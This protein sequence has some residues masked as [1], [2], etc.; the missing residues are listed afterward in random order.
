MIKKI[1]AL[2]LV[3]LVGMLFVAGC[4][5]DDGDDKSPTGDGS[6]AGSLTTR[7]DAANETV[8]EENIDQVTARVNG[9]TWDVFGRALSTAQAGKALIDYTSKLSGEVEGEAGGK[10]TVSGNMTTKMSGTSPSSVNYDF[11]CTFYDFSDD[12]E[13]W[14]GGKLTYK[15]DYN[16]TSM[17][18]NINITG[19]IRFNGAYEG[20]Q[21]Y[22]SVIK[23]NATTGESTYTVTTTTTSGGETFTTTQSF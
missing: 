2:T 4:S 16:Y 19:D 17:Q 12:G 14:L 23:M 10:A 22:S 5:D 11:T 8:T 18:Y 13:L 15:G 3:L 6:T 21:T 9:T 7:E 1:L 20:T